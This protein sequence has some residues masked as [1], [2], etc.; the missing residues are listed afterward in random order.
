MRGD[1]AEESLRLRRPEGSGEHRGRQGGG[2][3]EAGEADRMTRQMKDRLEEVLG[4][5]PERTRRSAEEPLPGT[6]VGPEARGR[7]VDRV[8]QDTGAAV[9]EG[10]GE[11]DLRPEPLEPVAAEVQRVE[12]GGADRHRVDRGA[13]VVEDAGDRELAGPRASPD[14]LRRLE[15]GDAD[16]GAGQLN[17]AGEPVGPRPDDDRVAHAGSGRTRSG[18]PVTSTGKSQDSSSQGRRSTMS[19]TFTQPS[20][21]RPVAAS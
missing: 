6:A 13:V 10:M 17:R 9:V 2:Q 14:R 15:H 8:P 12:E 20:S 19:A 21:I 11:V 5:A 7:L 4:E 1:A 3:A 16:A 18:G